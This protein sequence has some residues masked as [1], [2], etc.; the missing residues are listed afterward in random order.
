[1]V[2]RTFEIEKRDWDTFKLTVGDNNASATIR[3]FITSYGEKNNISEKKIYKEF[4]IIDEEFKKIKN[5][6]TFLKTKIESIEEKKRIE[7]LER[8]NKEE[9][10]KKKMQDIEYSTAKNN[11]SELV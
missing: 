7:E 6:W 5:K 9:K 4:E 3:N 11:L 2:I 8:I 1:M 10:E